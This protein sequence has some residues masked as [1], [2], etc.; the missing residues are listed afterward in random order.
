MNV[1]QPLINFDK[2]RLGHGVDRAEKGALTQSESDMG[3]KPKLASA[4]AP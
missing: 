3:K 4:L 2:P 1:D